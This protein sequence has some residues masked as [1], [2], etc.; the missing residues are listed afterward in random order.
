MERMV[1]LPLEVR[2]LPLKIGFNHQISLIL[3][4]K[5]VIAAIKN[6]K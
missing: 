3:A 5:T 1:I 6:M 2:C 4:T